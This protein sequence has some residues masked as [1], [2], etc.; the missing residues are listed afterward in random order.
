MFFDHIQADFFDL[1]WFDA[2]IHI[3][4]TD[5]KIDELPGLSKTLASYWA[6]R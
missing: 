4:V 6:G 3:H 2:Q 5:R 1:P